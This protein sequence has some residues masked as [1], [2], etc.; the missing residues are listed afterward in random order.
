MRNHRRKS[1]P[2]SHAS[3]QPVVSEVY[4]EHYACLYSAAASSSHPIFQRPLRRS[5]ES[6][7]TFTNDLKSSSS[8]AS[9]LQM[10]ADAAK[11]WSLNWRL[12]L[13]DEKCV[14]VSFGRVSSNAFVMH[15]PQ[16]VMRIDAKKD[17][18][19]WVSS[20]LS[21]SLH[22]EKLAQKAF[23]IL[24]LIRHPFP[25]LFA[26]T[27]K[28]SMG[29]RPSAARGTTYF[30]AKP[31]AVEKSLTSK[32]ER[33]PLTDK[34]KTDPGNLGKI[35]DPVYQSLECEFTGRKVRGS[36]PTSASR[37]L[38]S[39]GRPG[40]IPDLMLPSAG[41]A[42]RHRKGTLS[43]NDIFYVYTVSNSVRVIRKWM[44]VCA[45]G[46]KY[47]A[48]SAAVVGPYAPHIEPSTI[49]DFILNPS[50]RM[51]QIESQHD[52]FIS[53]PTGSGKSL[54]F[55][56]PAV[57]HLGVALV[58]SPLLALINDQLAHLQH[59]GINA[60]TINSKLNSKQRQS[61]IDSL[62]HTS[63]YSPH[64]PKLL[65]VTPE[66]IQTASFSVLANSLSNKDA[67]SYFVVDEAHCVSEWGHDF[68]PAYLGLG[69]ARQTFFPNI[70]CIALTATATA[71]VQDD[72]IKSLKLG[73][74][75]PGKGGL[76]SPSLGFRTFKCGV[77]RPNLFY[78]VTFSDL[79]ETPHED[80]F[81][82]A[83]ACLSWD[84]SVKKSWDHIGSGIV[85]CRTRSD[86][87]LMASSLSGRGLPTRA[88]HAG[89]TK[90]ARE[91]VQNDWS[92][93]VFPVVAATI[94]FGMGVDRAN[95]R[96]VFHWTL[97][98]SIASYYQESGRA[99]R[100]GKQ[101]FCR[102]YYS[103]QERNTVMFL[104][105]Q[106][107]NH[108]KSDS[109]NHAHRKDDLE[110]MVNF[111]ES[112]ICRHRQLAD[113]F[114]DESPR[115]INRCDVCVN[116]NRVSDNLAAFRSLAWNSTTDVQEWSNAYFDED[117]EAAS[118]SQLEENERKDRM[119]VIEEEF[120]KRRANADRSDVK[121]TWAAAPEQSSLLN[122]ND[123]SLTGITGKARDQTFQLLLTAMKS[124]FPYEDDGSLIKVCA[125][126]E[127]AMFQES[128]VAAMY[129][130][131]MARLITQVRRGE[132]TPEM[133]LEIVQAKA[134]HLNKPQ[135]SEL[136]DVGVVKTGP[137]ASTFPGSS[138]SDRS[139]QEASTESSHLVNGVAR[140]TPTP[141]PTDQPS[142]TSIKTEPY[143]IHSS[144]Y[145][146]SANQES[147]GFVKSKYNPDAE[148]CGQVATPANCVEKLDT[149]VFGIKRS[150][151]SDAEDI[152]PKKLETSNPKLCRV[153]HW[154]HVD[155]LTKQ[156]SVK[157]SLDSSPSSTEH[158]ANSKSVRYFWERPS[159]STQNLDTR[160]KVNASQELPTAKLKIEVA[161]PIARA[162]EIIA[163]PDNLE[164]RTPRKKDSASLDR[165]S[166]AT[167]TA[168]LV[169]A[170]LSRHF[171][172][173]R[174]QSKDVFKIV[175]KEFTRR[176]LA[177]G[178]S[179]AVLGASS[180]KLDAM[181][182]R[183][184]HSATKKP[185]G[186]P[187]DID[188][189]HLGEYLNNISS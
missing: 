38:S 28:Y 20:N 188:W 95:V 29:P 178:R 35:L 82:Y 187:G 186:D 155:P 147:T 14:H 68:R 132:T 164:K 185:I 120:R 3:D 25:V 133:A 119:A 77:F 85:Y 4:R 27:F 165:S 142:Q 36:N 63:L 114:N 180:R 30:S 108:R 174:F 134:K 88:Y 115:C 117:T 22:K 130:T 45:I 6:I 16:D 31:S 60:I 62:L 59:L 121:S 131:R 157:T 189:S 161:Q 83:S 71:R 75:S 84:G 40:S 96:F 15:E 107:T 143:E 57:C 56:L 158:K 86:C 169:V 111:V 105:N 74:S 39:L 151:E 90:T 137:N 145:E 144:R 166:Q 64:F 106:S 92:A 87:E 101:A 160:N 76:S 100:D 116:K 102:I 140:T 58:V 46:V 123:R 170:S 70:P 162:Q 5:C 37:L 41:V 80:V 141:T 129:R 149:T 51:S 152:S 125:T 156:S 17:L 159:S 18:G 69:K 181:V 13:S 91:N 34:N 8:N 65:Y 61:L 118:P 33:Q 55:Q 172:K 21:F 97:P 136:D 44:F 94:S 78:D 23:R 138:V 148:P 98:K 93:G 154:K 176:L 79:C 67:I 182:D 49:E 9:A 112:T 53:M 47:P 173:G 183:I 7:F 184:V 167:D 104:T 81:S 103:K 19:I 179:S 32:C 42:A 171:A 153:E 43:L 73:L 26:W 177:I 122:P 146:Y 135:P 110:K 99:G 109:K 89:L 66:Q 54:C 163:I 168:K 12:P 175:A 1:H 50:S 52:I 72:I 150:H 128:K 113:Y 127:Y 10:D 139:H 2:R 126:A 48:Q 11:Q 24:Q 124:H